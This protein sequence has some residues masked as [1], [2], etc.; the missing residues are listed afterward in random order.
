MTDALDP[1]SIFLA[2]LAAVVG[3][4]LGRAYFT[5]LRLTADL[6][7][8]GHGAGLPIALTVGRILIALAVFG[9]VA[10]VGGAFHLLAAFLGFL[11]ARFLAVR[12]AK[13]EA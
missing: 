10:I 4:G 12:A 3:F 2:V 5:A 11:V 9:A 8:S 13:R 1:V 7:A 6:Y